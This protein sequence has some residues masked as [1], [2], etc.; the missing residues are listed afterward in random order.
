VGVIYFQ[1]SSTSEKFINLI[2]EKKPD[3]SFIDGDHRIIGALQ[4]HI[5]VREHS[6]IIIH[7]DIFSDACLETVLLWNSLKKLEVGWNH[8][9]FIEQYP[10][11]KGRYLGIGVLYK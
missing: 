4:D 5:L 8:V 3:I 11:V 6:K 7:H 2:N 1:G 10:S 9:E